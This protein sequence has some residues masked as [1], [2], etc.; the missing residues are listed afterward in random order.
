MV[1]I[2]DVSAPFTAGW[3]RSSVVLKEAKMWFWILGF[4][5]QRGGWVKAGAY[6]EGTEW[7]VGTSR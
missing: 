5:K 7:S 2:N 1:D 3:R 6:D 4:E